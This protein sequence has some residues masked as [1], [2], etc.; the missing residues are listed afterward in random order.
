MKQVVKHGRHLSRAS[1]ARNRLV[2]GGGGDGA[3]GILSRLND[4]A[5]Y[6]LGLEHAWRETGRI[7]W[8]E[9]DVLITGD[10]P[11]L[12]ALA[13]R[14]AVKAGRHVTV[15]Q[16][17]N[18]DTWPYNLSLHP[19]FRETLSRRAKLDAHVSRY[20]EDGH[21]AI[22]GFLHRLFTEIDIETRLREG[23]VD[24]IEKSIPRMSSEKNEEEVLLY[25]ETAN[26]P[27]SAQGIQMEAIGALNSSLRL[28][29]RLVWRSGKRK[30]VLF[31]RTVVLTSAL[32]G[33]AMA[34]RT[35]NKTGNTTAANV[36]PFLLPCGTARSRASRPHDSLR[37]AVED[38]VRLT[39]PGFLREKK[40]DDKP[41]G[42]GL[43]LLR[44]HV[45]TNR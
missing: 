1:I 10:N 41:C 2:C 26:D 5:N 25:L 32:E 21:H 45:P 35:D 12:N 34:H 23:R 19:L 14:A 4:I 24:I 28:R 13:I 31:A 22:T 40:K 30:C 6:K 17:A 36:S 29:R 27:A 20:R 39:E 11:I 37:F 3:G 18:A 8:H 44:T 9:T 15:C 43:P 7:S 38:I 42:G 16:S 33:F